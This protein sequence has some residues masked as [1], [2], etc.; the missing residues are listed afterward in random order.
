VVLASKPL[1]EFGGFGFKT[2]GGQ[3]ASLGLKTR[4]GRFGGLG[5][6][7]IDGGFDRSRPQNRRVTD[8]RTRGGISKFALRRSDVGKA[9]GLLDR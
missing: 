8:R 1:E 9:P 3:F 7:T 4:C 2:I 5:L 6:K